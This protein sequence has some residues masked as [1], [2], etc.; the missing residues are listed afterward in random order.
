M[1]SRNDY[2]VT[3]DEI[4]GYANHWLGTALR[5]EYE[6]TKCTGS[7]LLQVLLIAAA[8]G[9][10]LLSRPGYTLWIELGILLLAS[11][12]IVGLVP[13]FRPAISPA[14]YFSILLALLSSSWLG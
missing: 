1:R 10:D 14:V 4:H 5:L 8:R 9:E 3:K 11:V 12:L 6:G 13:A 2:I 7:T